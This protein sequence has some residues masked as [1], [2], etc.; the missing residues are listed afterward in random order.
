MSA[1][2]KDGLAGLAIFVVALVVRLAF[3]SE[4]HTDL[5]L[6]IRELD[7][8]DNHT[9]SE[10]ARGIAEGDLLCENTVH[11]FHLWTA[12]VAPE[13]RW[14]EWYGDPKTYHQ[15]PLYA[16][17]IAAVYR[18]FGEAHTTFGVMQSLLGALTCLLTFV[19]ARRLMS[20]FA[21]IGAGG[22]LALCGP[23]YFYDAFLLRD[24]PLALLTIVLALALERAASRGRGVDWFKAGAALGLFTLGKETG[25]ALLVLTLVGAAIAYRANRGRALRTGGLVVLGW[26]LIASPAFLRNIAVDA[27]TF[28][29]STRGPEVIVAGNALLQDGVEWNPPAK[30]M[31][32]ILVE[33]EFSLPRTMLATAA[34]HRADPV[35]F[36]RLLWAKTTAFFND[37]E[38][39]NNVN[40][41]LA[42]AHLDTL[43][44]GFVTLSILSPLALLGFFLA[45]GSWRRMLTPM[46]L[47]VALSGSV[48]ALYVIA[49][50]RLHVFPLSA[51]FAGF[52]LDWLAGAVRARAFGRLAVAGGAL[53]LLWSWCL[54]EEESKIG[55]GH[56]FAIPMHKQL[57]ALNFDEAHRWL[58]LYRADA[59]SDGRLPYNPKVV[60]SFAALDAAFLD[61]DRAAALADGTAERLLALGT[62]Y[63]RLVEVTKL[64]LQHQL[65]SLAR[66]CFERALIIDPDVVGAQYG[67][68]LVEF[69]RN[70]PQ[71]ALHHFAIELSVNPE[72]RETLRAVGDLFHRRRQMLDALVYYEGAMAAGDMTPSTIIRSAEA[73]ID[74]NN[75]GYRVP[76]PGGRTRSAFE[77]R[78]ALERVRFAELQEGLD[79]DL[80]EPIARVMYANG[81]TGNDKALVDEAIETLERLY[82]DHRPLSQRLPNVIA[83]FKRIRDQRWP[84]ADPP[85]DPPDERP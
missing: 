31:R 75:R 65:A 20:R 36:V 3:L 66:S 18:L 48:I 21:A 26:L 12:E 24:G 67:L 37:Y 85:A 8:T 38:I 51:V 77:P 61:F 57:V 44:W 33:T 63:A 82:R 22:L 23:Y 81:I 68:G 74:P 47:F 49:R 79:P 4:Y 62:G 60:E 59:E 25:P 72:H 45:F 50:F 54:P 10:W 7:Q 73:L 71:E 19:L 69:G 39:P 78:T 2:S 43:R 16:Y 29:L 64:G 58:E 76:L 53:V 55:G 52:A 28:K 6:D 27:P 30:E 15:S 56:Q 9:F 70:H 83:G 34:T 46:L 40:Y 35:G 5:G 32:A 41:H 42:I 13:S 84:P 80:L 11:A 17:F 14:L 1:R